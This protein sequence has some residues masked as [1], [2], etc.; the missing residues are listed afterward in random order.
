MNQQFLSHKFS[1]QP[2]ES[3]IYIQ[4]WFLNEQDLVVKRSG[5]Y[6]ESAM[7]QVTQPDKE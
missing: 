6:I 4:V 3:P 2:T 7:L 5:R 1:N